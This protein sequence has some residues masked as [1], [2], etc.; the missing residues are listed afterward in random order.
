MN[1]QDWKQ[2]ANEAAWKA[3]ELY[4]AQ[5]FKMMEKRRNQKV[6]Q[7]AALEQQFKIEVKKPKLI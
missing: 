4:E 5:D 6:L 2:R 1:D 3:Q 7:N